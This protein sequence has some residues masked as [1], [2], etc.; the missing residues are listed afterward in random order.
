M[1]CT[2]SVEDAAQII[3]SKKPA[4]RVFMTFGGPQAHGNSLTVAARY[5]KRPYSSR[6]A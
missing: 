6:S 1:K 5:R 3:D 4:R 2:D